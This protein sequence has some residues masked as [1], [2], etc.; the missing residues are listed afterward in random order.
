MS[1]CP[2]RQGAVFAPMLLLL[3][4][5][6]E[7][8]TLL[9]QVTRPENGK[10]VNLELVVTSKTTVALQL[11]IN[12]SVQTMRYNGTPAVNI[13]GEVKDQTLQPY[14]GSA[15][16]LKRGGF[17]PRLAEGGFTLSPT[18]SCRTVHLSPGSFLVLPTPVGR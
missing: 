6:A 16:K 9:L 12:I 13:Q 5:H 18:M 14:T 10:D 11:S 7:L 4:K 17:E 2:R 15:L 1:A 8:L 3:L